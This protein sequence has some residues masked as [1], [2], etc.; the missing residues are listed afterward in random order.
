MSQTLGSENRTN[1]FLLYFWAGMDTVVQ[2]LYDKY[3]KAK[4]IF[5]F[6]CQII[7]DSYK[8]FYNV[9]VFW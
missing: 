7:I 2:V 3:H 4:M 9:N 1:I 8:S 5:Y 6:Y